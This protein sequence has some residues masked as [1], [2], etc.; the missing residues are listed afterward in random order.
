MH[1]YIHI[2]IYIHTCTCICIC[3][4]VWLQEQLH[5]DPSAFLA[6]LK[7]AAATESPGDDKEAEPAL[8]GKED[9]GSSMTREK[10]CLQL[11]WTSCSGPTVIVCHLL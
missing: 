4:F 5:P 7:E 6:L 11:F 9:T 3:S 10:L 8:E 2:Y 1:L